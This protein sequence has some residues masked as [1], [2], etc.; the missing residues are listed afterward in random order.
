MYCKHETD[1]L[2][3]GAAS[4]LA[5]ACWISVHPQDG[6]L[7]LVLILFMQMVKMV[8]LSVR[9]WLSFG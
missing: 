4:V 2:L 8:L 3:P 5:A 9:G 7:I 1:V 6:L